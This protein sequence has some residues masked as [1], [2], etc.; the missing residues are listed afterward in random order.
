[1][2]VCVRLVR[3]PHNAMGHMPWV[4]QWSVISVIVAFSA[5]NYSFFVHLTG[6]NKCWTDSDLLVT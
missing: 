6:N 3:F 4:D 5:H 1:M 2:F